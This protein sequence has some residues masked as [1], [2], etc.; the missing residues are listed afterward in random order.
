MQEIEHHIKAATYIV[1][2]ST[3]WA[4]IIIH[5]Q[6]KNTNLMVTLLLL[7][8]ISLETKPLLR[9][10]EEEAGTIFFPLNLLPDTRATGATKAPVTLMADAH[11]ITH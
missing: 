7:L 11:A 5:K 8:E 6:G 1:L 4:E 10:E 2:H 3:S 9:E